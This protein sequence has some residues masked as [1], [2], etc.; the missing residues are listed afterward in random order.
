MVMREFGKLVVLE[1]FWVK[2]FKS[3]RDFE[4]NMPSKITIIAGANGSGKTA[5]VEVFE[6]L[7]YILD[8]ARGLNPNPFSRW[9][10]Y[11]NVVWEHNEDFSVTIG[12]KLKLDNVKERVSKIESNI[13]KE[14]IEDVVRYS[15]TDFAPMDI[16]YELDITGK[17]GGFK[18]LNENLSIISK[19]I[20]IH[21]NTARNSM[22][23][24]ADI[25]SELY[26]F[27]ESMSN[28][29]EKYEQKPEELLYVLDLSFREY[30]NRYAR[31]LKLTYEHWEKLIPLLLDAVKLL[32][33]TSFKLGFTCEMEE[34]YFVLKVFPEVERDVERGTSNPQDY[35][36]DLLESSV[37]GRGCVRRL[38]R[39]V[40]EHL[41]IN[42]SSSKY[43]E[44]VDMW[45]DVDINVFLEIAKD[46]AARSI[47]KSILHKAIYAIFIAS[48]VV[49]GFIDGITII[50]NIDWKLV[51]TPQMLERQERL[52]PDASNFL[53]FFFTLTGGNVNEDLKE[54]L[55]YSFPGYEDINVVFE[56]TTDGRVFIRLITKGLR[57]APISIPQ[58]VLKTL[59][60]ESLLVWKPTLLVIDEFENSLHPE[61]QQFLLDEFR[62]SNIY[63]IITT[64]STIPLNYV[65]NIE[66]AVIL[67]LENGETK[68]YRL[69]RDVLEI[70]RSKKLTLSELLLSSLL[71]FK[72]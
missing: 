13:V 49:Y 44:L 67:R 59:I 34:T 24:V 48:A 38:I 5:L 3:F 32:A 71:E 47:V 60:L 62:S 19:D 1:K 69:S 16:I 37:L 57:L 17:G 28:L 55:K 45:K 58:G 15:G 9:W 33:P 22:T 11:N 40:R 51:V 12:F 70:L 39:D 53:Q 65:K 21:I 8:W 64:H 54:A 52:K 2:N 61:L 68:A 7:T 30:V 26:S 25:A 46:I 35:V 31:R 43:R 36:I 56:L 6:L 20:E 63:I 27:T 23:I 14:I 50:K 10:G 66:E 4:L 72:S 29:R 41:C 18:I 42:T